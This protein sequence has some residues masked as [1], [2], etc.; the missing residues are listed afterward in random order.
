MKL[1]Q[2]IAAFAIGFISLFGGGNC[3]RSGSRG[4]LRCSEC[5]SRHVELHVARFKRTLYRHRY[6]HASDAK[7]RTVYLRRDEREKRRAQRR[8][9]MALR[10]E[11]GRVRSVRCGKQRLGRLRGPASADAMTVTLADT[12]PSDPTNG[13]STYHFAASTISYTSDWKKNGTPMHV[14]QTC[15]KS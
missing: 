6:I 14:Q 5:S 10:Y 15:T 8:G 12:Y 13:T 1:L 2:L 7:P 9:R 4:E 3:N 11:E